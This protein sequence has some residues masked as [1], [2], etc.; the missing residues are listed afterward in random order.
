MTP[1]TPIY[2]RLYPLAMPTGYYMTI[3]A[4]LLFAL[5]CFLFFWFVFFFFFFFFFFR[6]LD[7]CRCNSKVAVDYREWHSPSSQLDV[8]V[9]FDNEYITPLLINLATTLLVHVSRVTKT[10]SVQRLIVCK[11]KTASKSSQNTADDNVPVVVHEQQHNNVRQPPFNGEQNTPNKMF[12][13][14]SHDSR[15][16][17]R[18]KKPAVANGMDSRIDGNSGAFA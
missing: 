12:E 7:Y 9:L 15:S 3:C 14:Q 10:A 16:R 5:F 17:H 18:S 8:A 13:R 11:K 4:V 6:L 2:R 1:L